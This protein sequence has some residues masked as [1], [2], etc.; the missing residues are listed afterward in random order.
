M[1]NRFIALQDE[2]ANDPNGYGYS[3][4]TDQQ[5]YDRLILEDIN[6]AGTIKTITI[7][8][9]L[10]LEDA[11]V[12]VNNLDGT[13]PYYDDAYHVVLVLNTFESFDMSIPDH[14]TVY[15]KIIA[16]IVNNSVLTQAQA[17]EI[18]ATG[19]YNISRDT[20]IGV[21]SVRIGEVEQAR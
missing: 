11:W 20:E 14:V 9:K 2:F 19:Y 13:E 1:T 4:M 18:T 17:D 21:S 12:L 6:Q 5:R 10:E 3:G 8:A 16:L 7:A 15:L